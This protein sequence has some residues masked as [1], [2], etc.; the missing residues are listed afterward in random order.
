[1]TQQLEDA[2]WRLLDVNRNAMKH[3]S[4]EVQLPR[5]I[6]EFTQE[7]DKF[8]DDKIEQVLARKRISKFL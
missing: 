7:L 2:L 3:G 6:G 8:I 5:A 1:M 4:S